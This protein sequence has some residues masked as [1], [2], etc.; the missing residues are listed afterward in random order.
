MQSVK[1]V[2]GRISVAELQGSFPPLPSWLPCK[3]CHTCRH[4]HALKSCKETNNTHLCTLSTQGTTLPT[5]NACGALHASLSMYL[6]DVLNI[7]AS[8]RLDYSASQRFSRLMRNSPSLLRTIHLFC[9]LWES[10]MVCVLFWGHQVT[11][12]LAAGGWGGGLEP[13]ETCGNRVAKL[14]AP[15]CPALRVEECLYRQDV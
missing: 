7:H 10:S 14:H 13:S 15:A 4:L 2:P 1:K 3:C 5:V 11:R 8:Y 12:I 6:R 9:L